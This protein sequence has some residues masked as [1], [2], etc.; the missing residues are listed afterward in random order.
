M[1]STW[2]LSLPPDGK[3][4]SV[5]S[6]GEMPYVTHSQIEYVWRDSERKQLETS[7]EN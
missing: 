4:I 3:N 6:I 1:V 2:L 7:G 5:M